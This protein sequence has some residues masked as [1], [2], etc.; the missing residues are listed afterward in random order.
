MC[1]KSL[2]RRFTRFPSLVENELEEERSRATVAR[3]AGRHHPWRL[4]GKKGR[5]ALTRLG[6]ATCN[7]PPRLSW[8]CMS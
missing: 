2:A 5:M 1:A 6:F 4:R 7:G 3:A 8:D